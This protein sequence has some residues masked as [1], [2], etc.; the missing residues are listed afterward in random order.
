MRFARTLGVVT[1]AA[2]LVGSS[3]V[4]ARTINI[5]PAYSIKEVYD[6]AFQDLVAGDTVRIHH[7][8]RPYR[9]VIRISGRGTKANRIKIIG[10]P[11]PDGQLPILDGD[12]ASTHP[13]DRYDTG[14]GQ[15]DL[16]G[17]GIVTLTRGPGV[18]R[19]ALVEW[20]V[21]ENLEIRNARSE[22]TAYRYFDYDGVE[23]PW[24][25]ASAGIYMLGARQIIIR[26]CKIHDCANGVFFKTNDVNDRVERVL[27][28]RN[29]I[30]NNAQDPTVDPTGDGANES[31]NVYGEGQYIT[32]RG[33]RFGPTFRR[34]PGA[35]LKSRSAG[36]VI[37]NNW[38]EGSVRPSEENG[39][40]LLDIVHAQDSYDYVI[41]NHLNAYRNTQVLGNLII[42][43]PGESVTA[44]HYGGDDDGAIPTYRRG[45]LWFQNNTVVKTGSRE[46]N[47]TYFQDYHFVLFDIETDRE[48]V[49]A[50]NNVFH[51]VKASGQGIQNEPILALTYTPGRL[52]LGPNWIRQGYE[53]V[54]NNVPPNVSKGNADNLIVGTNPRF[55]SLS[56]RNYVPAANSPLIDVGVTPGTRYR[57]LRK[58][59][60]PHQ[61]LKNRTVK[62]AA[63]D[64]GA[65]ER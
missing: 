49:N 8:N 14:N 48:T 12:G 23:R 29:Y 11:G 38:F 9:G 4:Q 5:G 60:V 39:N 24:G 61:K 19:G 41:N 44:V 58:Q 47:P 53:T 17:S 35:A 50:T 45:N 31:H 13:G 3:D 26:R 7:R 25:N 22:P 34:R 10:V 6:F 42:S 33:N 54:R 52:K 57:K 56:N 30:Y 15:S 40:R 16:V 20:V 37:E 43:G 59:Y 36:L 46:R 55:N 18:A 32:Y 64:L 63:R 1:L 28:D 62:G 51:S 27:F 2:T 21:I 65:F